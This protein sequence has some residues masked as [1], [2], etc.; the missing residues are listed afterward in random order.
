MTTI[1]YSV[2][3]TLGSIV[4]KVTFVKASHWLYDSSDASLVGVA[5]VGKTVVCWRDVG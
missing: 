2:P 4:W 5:P 1:L 3:R